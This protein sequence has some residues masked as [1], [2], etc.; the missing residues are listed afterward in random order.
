MSKRHIK[1]LT[2]VQ[3]AYLAGFFDGEGCI[4]I[5]KHQSK[6]TPTPIYNLYVI[7]AQTNKA[8]ID[9]ML[10][11]VGLGSVHLYKRSFE[12]HKS[13]NDAYAWHLSGRHAADFLTAIKDYVKL[14][15]FQLDV[16]LEFHATRN[17]QKY[18]HGRGS[19]VPAEIIERREQLAQMLKA[20]KKAQYRNTDTVYVEPEKK[21]EIQR[22]LL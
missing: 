5:G 9:D 3:K 2:E 16:A 4:H 20:D 6:N 8:I 12:K 14:K 1:P 17:F 21:P 13:D 15:R 19:K 22:K 10:E 7:V 18:H 11:T